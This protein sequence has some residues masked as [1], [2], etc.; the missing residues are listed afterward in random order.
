M[1]YYLYEIKNLVNGKI[2]VGVHKTT[3]INDDY[4]GSGKVIKNAIKKYG[5]INFS[6]TI[7]ETFD[8]ESDMFSREK[9]IVNDE[10]LNRHDVYNLR[11][12]GLGGF[13]H[14]NKN[15]L[16]DRTGKSFT[17]EQKKNIAEGRKKAVT[18]EHRKK[19]SERMTGNK[20]G[21]G[22]KGRKG[23]S[24]SDE[25]KE[26]IRQSVLKRIEKKRVE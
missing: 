18:G 26:K 20:I 21:L 25:H 9:N 10:F 15:G 17:I 13:D 16:N 19:L 1:Y 22:N 2:Y 4:M 23:S 5:I 24:M 8:N 3:N 6:K 12:G 11:C 14:I 7:L